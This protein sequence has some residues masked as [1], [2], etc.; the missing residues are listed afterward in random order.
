M[1]QIQFAQLNGFTF[2][3]NSEY[4][5]DLPLTL[6]FRCGDILFNDLVLASC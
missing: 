5:G 3:V 1:T 6:T 4:C 2:T